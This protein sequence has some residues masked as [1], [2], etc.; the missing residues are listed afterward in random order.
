M[1]GT[2]ESE[3][4][5]VTFR[6]RIQHYTHDRLYPVLPELG[7]F[8]LLPHEQ[9]ARAVDQNWYALDLQQVGAT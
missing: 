5:L 7:I 8:L 2:P 9:E 1:R 4:K 3:A 6:E